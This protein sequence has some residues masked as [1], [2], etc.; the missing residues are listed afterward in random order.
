MEEKTFRIQGSEDEP[1]H[2]VVRRFDSGN[3]G[4]A[5]NCRAG[6]GGT[7]CK[8]RVRLLMG[9]DEG[10]VHGSEHLPTVVEWFSASELLRAVESMREIEERIEADRKALKTL[11][12]SIAERMAAEVDT[13]RAIEAG[14]LTAES[15]APPGWLA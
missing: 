4:I 11:K 14:E 6:V 7:L 1:Y 10:I 12:A 13:L 15:F 9:S 2:V 8:H 5:C 3:L